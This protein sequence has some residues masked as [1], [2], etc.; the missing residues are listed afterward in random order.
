MRLSS[1]KSDKFRLRNK[2]ELNGQDDGY[3]SLF[4]KSSLAHW[5]EKPQ[6]VANCQRKLLPVL[7]TVSNFL[8]GVPRSTVNPVE[9]ARSSRP[10]GL[11]TGGPLLLISSGL[12][13][14]ITPQGPCQ[15]SSAMPL[16]TTDS[17]AQVTQDRSNSSNQSV[18]IVNFSRDAQL[19]P[20]LQEL[21]ST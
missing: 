5:R 13:S 2:I 12:A 11:S 15:S 16:A 1:L 19:V 20:N 4:Q 10:C 14:N 3:V 21:Q 8:R 9:G 7:L 18:E 17:G 6:G